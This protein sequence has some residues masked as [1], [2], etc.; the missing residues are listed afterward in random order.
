M[1]DDVDLH[2]HTA[3]IGCANE[4]MSVPALLERCEQ[5][6]IT[7]IAITDHLNTPDQLPTHLQIKEDLR[8][9]QGPVKMIWGVE[10]NVIDKDTGAVSIN[11]QQIEEAGFEFVIGGPHSTYF[12]EPDPKGIIDLQH[13]L[14]MAVVEN[15]LIDVLVHP[16]WFGRGEFENGTLAWLTDLQQV[17]EEYI[18]E[19]AEAAVS[20]GTAIEMNGSAIIT[21]PCLGPEF[22]EDYKRYFWDLYERGASFTVC[23]DAHD[24]NQIASTKLAAQYLD[25]IGVPDER[26][27]IPPPSDFS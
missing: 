6:G 5:E 27:V 20:T 25:E 21:H 24:I 11:E 19:L 26:I 7:T 3:R 15:P 4:T 17:P 13:K 2:I 14:M 1:R 10:V 8:A 12:S 22:Q 23:S 9:Y 18:D 16:W